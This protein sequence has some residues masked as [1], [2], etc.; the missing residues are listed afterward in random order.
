MRVDEERLL[1]PL[2]SIVET[3]ILNQLKQGKFITR[4]KT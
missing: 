1:E 4:F 2:I 3:M